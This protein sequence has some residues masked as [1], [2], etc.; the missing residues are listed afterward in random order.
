MNIE[1]RYVLMNIRKPRIPTI[2]LH[3]QSIV[4]GLVCVFGLVKDIAVSA[5]YFT[6]NGMFSLKTVRNNHIVDVNEWN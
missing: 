1:L 4:G 5:R 6:L 3:A 2:R